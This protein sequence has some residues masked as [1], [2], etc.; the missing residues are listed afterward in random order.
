MDVDAFH[1]RTTEEHTEALDRFR[2]H[3]E[4]T[5]AASP[6]ELLLFLESLTALGLPWK[7]T[8]HINAEHWKP[9]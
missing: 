8:I 3:Y 7:I 6:D 1:E 2:Q 5:N 9:S 4:F